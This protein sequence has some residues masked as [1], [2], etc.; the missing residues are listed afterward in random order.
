MDQSKVHLERGLDAMNRQDF[1]TAVA[2]LEEATLAEPTSDEAFSY[3]G[4]A[5]AAVE[6]HNA[7]IGAFKRATELRPM[8]ARMRYNL[9]QAYEIAGVPQEAYHEYCRAL[10]LDPSYTLAWQAC[11]ALKSK[12]AQMAANDVQLAA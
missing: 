9:A 11:T 1:E 4:A 7:A 10:R 6:R 2:E 8:D 3:L 12:M 5:Y